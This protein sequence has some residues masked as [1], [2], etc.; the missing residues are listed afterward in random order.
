MTVSVLLTTFN[1]AGH[2]RKCMP[3]LLK[4][5]GIDEVIVVDDGSQDNTKQEVEVLREKFPN[6]EIIYIYNHRLEK[7]LN[8]SQPKNI[9]LKRARGDVV[10]YC[11][12]EMLHIGNT[13][14]QQLEWHKKRDNVFI[15]AGTIWFPFAGIVQNLTLENFENPI[16]I[17]QRSDIKEWKEGYQPN[18]GEIAVQRTVSATYIASV[19]R[20]HLMRIRGFEERITHWGFED[21]NM[22]HRLGMIG[23][24]CISD[25]KIQ[26]VHVAHGYSGCF[27]WFSI[28]QALHDKYSQQAEANTDKTD[29]EWGVKE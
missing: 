19:R 27:E 9:A 18:V 4:Q 20:K 22:Q 6:T 1:R 8:S 24:D 13:I 7:S 10:F 5:P 16:T 21:I 2:I 23:V 17:T 26:A 14:E 3:S 29:D 12:A 15:S 28:S 25:P 11:E